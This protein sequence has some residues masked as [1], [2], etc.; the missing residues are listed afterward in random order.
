MTTRDKNNLIWAEFMEI[1]HGL[2]K[3]VLCFASSSIEH[4]LKAD[5]FVKCLRNVGKP[6]SSFVIGYV[7]C[8]IFLF[9]SFFLHKLNGLY[10]HSEWL[11]FLDCGI[12][13]FWKLH[14]II[15]SQ[16]FLKIINIIEVV[17]EIMRWFS[18]YGVLDWRFEIHVFSEKPRQFFEIWELFL[19]S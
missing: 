2:R 4:V 17:Y 3:P 5:S 7:S 14:P 18:S 15:I 10:G 8:L 19:F 12:C 1:E 9:F 16:F 13:K 11:T 6:W